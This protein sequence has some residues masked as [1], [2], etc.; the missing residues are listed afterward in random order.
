MRRVCLCLLSLRRVD[1]D[2]LQ[3]WCLSKRITE[4]ILLQ[5]WEMVVKPADSLKEN[6]NDRLSA[7]VS[8]GYERMGCR[9]VGIVGF[10]KLGNFS[11]VHKLLSI[12][13]LQVNIS[14]KKLEKEVILRW[15]LYGTEPEKRWKEKYQRS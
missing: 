7:K 3:C 4:D 1:N 15:F 8:F 10:G 2:L 12:I 5:R 14:M 9:K 11:D 13:V 6:G